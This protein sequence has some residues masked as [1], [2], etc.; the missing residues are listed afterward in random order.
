MKSSLAMTSS[1][2]WLSP[3]VFVLPAMPY[4]K[5]MNK[6]MQM[7][8]TMLGGI[9]YAEKNHCTIIKP[10]EIDSEKKLMRGYKSN[11]YCG[12]LLKLL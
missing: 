6:I 3:D 10:K 12:H 1:F 5:T 11:V 4:L 8:H 2:C 9:L 7:I